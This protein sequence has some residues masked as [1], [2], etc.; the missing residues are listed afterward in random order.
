MDSTRCGDHGPHTLMQIDERRED[1][2]GVRIT[3]VRAMHDVE[4]LEAELGTLE[5]R[6]LGRRVD[7]PHHG[8]PL[9]ERCRNY[10]VVR[11]CPPLPLGSRI[12]RRAPR[13]PGWSGWHVNGVTTWDAAHSLAIADGSTTQMPSRATAM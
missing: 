1:L 5:K 9:T 6:Q 13:A 10:F 11:H 12:V 3:P 7:G 8:E 4:Q 2:A